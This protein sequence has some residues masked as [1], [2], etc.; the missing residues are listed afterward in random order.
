MLEQGILLPVEEYQSD[1]K[2]TLEAFHE[3]YVRLFLLFHQ[4]WRTGNPENL[5]D[6]GKYMDKTIQL[7]KDRLRQKT[8]IL[9]TEELEK[10]EDTIV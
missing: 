8:T 5:L 9:T 6:F 1:R 3:E 10:M 7:A 2:N 4:T